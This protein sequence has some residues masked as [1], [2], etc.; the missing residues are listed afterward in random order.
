MLRVRRTAIER[1]EAQSF[2]Q[3]AVDYERLGQLGE[4]KLIDSWV[5]SACCPGPAARSRPG[6]RNGGHAVLLVERFTRVDA[7][8]LSGPMIELANARRPRPNVTYRLWGAKTVY[9]R[10]T[11]WFSCSVGRLAGSILGL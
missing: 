6:L 9:K 3:V 8:D 10:L 1:A 7:I 2:D 11:C 5:E 4:N